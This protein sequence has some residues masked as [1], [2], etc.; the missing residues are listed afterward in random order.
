MVKKS[1]YAPLFV[2]FFLIIGFGKLHA[3]YNNEWID[4]SKTYFKFKVG[5]N[6]LYRISYNALQNAGL[7]STPLEQFQLWRN[8]REV[9][10]FTSNPSG[11]MSPNDF[12]E[13]YGVIND[14]KADAALYKKPEFQ[15]ADKWSLQTDT[16]A[17]F[18]TTSDGQ[19]ARI[20]DAQN[21]V[22]GNQLAPDTYFQYTLSK[23]FRDQINPGE[24]RSVS[25]Y[26]YSSS[27]DN[28]EGW[29]SNNIQLATPLVDQY[30]D[31]LLEAMQV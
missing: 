17:Y 7:S 31:F 4:Y 5:Q 29:T 23:N 13:F 3:Q 6:G 21:N 11:I 20:L 12:I 16:A 19:H 10:I 26:V 22:A 27:Y 9:A 24:G 8:G 15:L 25:V 30:T 18:L 14:G 28:G 1:L 2:L